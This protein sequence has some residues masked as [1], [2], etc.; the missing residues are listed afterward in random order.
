MWLI[1]CL[2]LRRGLLQL[3]EIAQ[4]SSLTWLKYLPVSVAASA[5]MAAFVS[6]G[7]SAEGQQSPST[8]RE[9]SVRRKKPGADVEERVKNAQRLGAVLDCI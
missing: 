4:F 1:S 9:C 8:R 6:L 5:P 7:M 2:S 3:G